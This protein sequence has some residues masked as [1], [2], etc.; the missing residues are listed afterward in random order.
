MYVGFSLKKKK[1]GGVLCI[2]R[3]IEYL[4]YKYAN[5]LASADPF[6]WF[7]VFGPARS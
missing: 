1:G 5:L 2:N 6:L 4:E 3:L 7:S